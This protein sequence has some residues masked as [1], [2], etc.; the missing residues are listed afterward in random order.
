MRRKRGRRI[1]VRIAVNRSVAEEFRIR[2]PGNHAEHALLLRDSQSRLETDEIPH[3]AVTVFAPQLNYCVRL[4]SCARIT[5]PY[6]LQRTE[7]QR[8][9]SAIGRNFDEH[10]T[11][12]VRSFIELMTVELI[13]GCQR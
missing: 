2:E 7:A 6:R 1:Q 5:K 11:F 12:E 8:F 9:Y 3:S 13:R 4:T 10:A